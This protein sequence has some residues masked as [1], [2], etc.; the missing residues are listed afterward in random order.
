MPVQRKLFVVA[1]VVVVGVAGALLF[2]KAPTPEA[3]KPAVATGNSAAQ[4]KPALPL[5]KPAPVSHLTGRIDPPEQ[6]LDVRSQ[7]SSSFN[8]RAG[9]GL[10]TM[11]PT[12]AGYS[13]LPSSNGAASSSI[14]SSASAAP[15]AGFSELRRHRIADGDTL[16]GLAVRYLGSADRYR[17][18]YELN[19]EALANPDLLPIGTELKIPA[20]GS[21][22]STPGSINN[23]PMVPV[24]PRASAI[25]PAAPGAA[26]GG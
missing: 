1:I 16:S 12:G 3:D 21:K 10:S 9:F 8:D 4:I 6:A 11:P 5:E 17:E 14:A 23:R 7:P 26:P 22:V 24:A 19:R 13:T 20:L 15:G 2:R 18:I 25:S